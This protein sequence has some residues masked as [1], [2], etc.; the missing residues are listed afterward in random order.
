MDKVLDKEAGKVNSNSF[1]EMT[2][3]LFETPNFAVIASFT[4]RR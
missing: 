2:L 1:I 4:N 3:R